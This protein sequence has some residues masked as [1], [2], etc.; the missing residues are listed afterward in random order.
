MRPLNILRATSIILGVIGFAQVG[1]A[2]TIVGSAH[3]LRAVGGS[4]PAAGGEICVV[5]H[6]PHNNQNAATELLWNRASTGAV[7]TT[8]SSDT[9]DGGAG[10]RGTA[11]PQPSGT[12]LQCLSCHD[13]TLAVDAYGSVPGTGLLMGAIGSGSGDF[14]TDLS[15]EHPI[16]VPI[17]G[18]TDGNINVNPVG[19]GGP[20]P[21]FGGNIECGTCHDVHNENTAGAFLLYIDN[22]ADSALCQEC[23][24]K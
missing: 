23:H 14:G 17:A 5:C 6:A 16:S 15:N 24:Q 7:F 10:G 12:S 2:Q 21:L 11:A 19:P 3:D 18:D 13:G 9:F 4:L 8:Y 1:F 22:S 20:L